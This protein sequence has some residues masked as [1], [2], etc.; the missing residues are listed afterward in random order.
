MLQNIEV[1]IGTAF[2]DVLY[3][4]AGDNTLQGGAGN[5]SLYGLAG[6]DHLDGGLGADAM[7]GGLGDDVY[8]VDNVGDLVTELAGEGRDRVE[9][10]LT[11]YALTAN[12][13]DLTF[14]GT[15]D[16]T[17]IGNALANVIIG[18]T[19]ADTLRGAGGA[20]TLN[21]GDGSDTADYSTSRGCSECQSCN[22]RRYRRRRCWRHVQ[23]H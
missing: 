13:E 9:T 7:A 10:T 12:V 19:G 21:G 22:R 14:V 3:G 11:T 4:D 18:G 6:Q 1:L 20:D 5:D 15:G 23:Q 17:G 16:F 2:A 8:R